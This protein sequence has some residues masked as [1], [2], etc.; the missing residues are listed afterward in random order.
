MPLLLAFALSSIIAGIAFWRG[1]LS[2]SGATGAVIIGAMTFGFGGWTWG[3]LLVLFF[4]TSSALSRYREADKRK[5]AEASEKGSRRDLA[6][7]LA[8][9]GVP[10]GLAL[11][12]SLARISH[13]TSG[14]GRSR[15]E[16]GGMGAVF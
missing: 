13:R 2:A 8:N 14:V 6:Q 15:R 11:A 10:A 9:G 12:N 7:V 5:A 3:V 1:S 4:V 16:M